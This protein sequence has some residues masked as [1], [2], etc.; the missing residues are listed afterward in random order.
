MTRQAAED[1]VEDLLQASHEYEHAVV[2]FT[3]SRRKDYLEAK[4]KVI[5]ALCE[6]SSHEQRA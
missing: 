1:L 2:G 3:N 5:A 6:P 4:E